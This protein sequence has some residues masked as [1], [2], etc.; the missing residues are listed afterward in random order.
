[1]IKIL[2]SVAAA[3]ALTAAAAALTVAGPGVASAQP[4]AVAGPGVASAQPLA[5]A[6]SGVASAQPLAVAGS[7]VAP[8]QPRAER[9]SLTPASGAT[10]SQVPGPAIWPRVPCATGSLG[11]ASTEDARV[12]LPASL[13]LCSAYKT[14]YRFTAVEFPAGYPVAF[15][16]QSRL[17]PF[18]PT[19]PTSVTADLTRPAPG[20]PLGVCL[21]TSTST[22][23]ACVRV[24]TS[25][26]WQVTVTPLSTDDPAVATAQ[27]VE[28][29]D[30]SAQPID[31]FCGT[32]LELPAY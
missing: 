22:R 25:T 16:Y 11:A 21:M 10:V 29:D 3:T 2:G 32:C 9:T 12:L 7:G 1:M 5:V 31:P 30:G 18:E 8:A 28:T 15:A 24:D 23:V 13:S 19:G 26:D 6:G 4:L 27:V 14:D 17:L 20:Q